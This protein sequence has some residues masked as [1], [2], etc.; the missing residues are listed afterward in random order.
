MSDIACRKRGLS[1]ARNSGDLDIS[2]FDRA[3][4]PTLSCSNHSCGVGGSPVE[5]KHTAIQILIQDL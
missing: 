4:G 1:R 2:N 5:I 3:P